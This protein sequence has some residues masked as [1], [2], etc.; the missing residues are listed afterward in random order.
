MNATTRRY[1][2]DWLRVITIGL[3]LIYHISIVFQPWAALIG[4]IQSEHSLTSIWIP[5]SMINVWRIPLLFF[6]SGMGVCFAMRKR[7][8]KQ[9]VLE[10]TQRILLPFL[11]GMLFIV[12]LHIMIWQQY[13]HQDITFAP[14]Q[15]H[16]WFLKNIFIYAIL[17]SPVFFYLKNHQNNT[18]DKWLKK[19]FSHPLGLLVIVIA[20]LVEAVLV[21]PETYELYALTW[22]GFFLG[23]LAFLFGF[24]IIHSGPKIWQTIEKWRWVFILLAFI[25][26]VFRFTQFELKAPNFMMAIE[27]CIWIFAVF[28]FGFKHL[29]HPSAALNYLS[30]SAYPVYIIHM[31]FLYLSSV[32]ILPLDIPT[33]AKFILI[34]IATFSGC[35]ALY[36]F[37]RRIRVLRPLFGLKTKRR[38]SLKQHKS[39]KI[40]KIHT[41][42]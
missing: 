22:H 7:N 33:T 2:I 9:L 3:L 14:Q 15:G 6:V 30:Q 27:S 20:F 38:E 21:Q 35:F 19:L 4:F 12:P 8:W 39:T 5:M 34:V 11:F 36:E 41:I 16:L 18:V 1:D 28:S 17:L 29:N 31:V 23:L 32:L 10:R 26:F 37:I 13:Y 42:K 24:M 25:L 40:T